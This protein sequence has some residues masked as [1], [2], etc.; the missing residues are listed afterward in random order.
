MASTLGFGMAFKDLF[1]PDLPLLRLIYDPV[2]PFSTDR[3]LEQQGLYPFLS[4]FNTLGQAAFLF[5]GQERYLP[6]FSKIE[7]HGWGR[8]VGYIP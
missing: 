4:L 8:G 1:G 6:D 2:H 5:R 7:S 3:T